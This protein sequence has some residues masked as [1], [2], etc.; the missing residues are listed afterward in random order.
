MF[1]MLKINGL[2]ELGL[3]IDKPENLVTR[4]GN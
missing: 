2:I 1:T 3:P 4:D